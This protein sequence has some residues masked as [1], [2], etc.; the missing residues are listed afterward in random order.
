MNIQL[1]LHSEFYGVKSSYDSEICRECKKIVHSFFFKPVFVFSCN[2]YEITV[3]SKKK[4]FC[5]S[6]KEYTIIG[7]VEHV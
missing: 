5:E 1:G 3:I 2:Q 6:Y 4:N 7:D